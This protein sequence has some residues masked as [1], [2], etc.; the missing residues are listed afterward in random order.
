[1]RY[2]RGTGPIAGS[3]ALIEGRALV[4]PWT[5]A[6][7]ATVR[8]DAE[9]YFHL[10]GAGNIMVRIGSGYALGAHAA[11]FYLSSFDTLR[12]VPFGDTGL[13]LGRSYLFST[14]ELQVPLHGLIQVR[15]L[16]LEGIAGIDAGGVGGSPRGVWDNRVF[17]LVT[18]VNIG[19]GPLIWRLHV[20][21][22]V[23]IGGAVT[24]NRGVWNVNFSIAYRYY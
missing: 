4:H 3:A 13:L 23:A 1:L 14:A 5:R 19:L 12:G 10:G 17:D 2:Y 21:K 8:L 20:A 15:F 18:G 9:H 11:E 7:A 24:P 22:P 6:R 16:D